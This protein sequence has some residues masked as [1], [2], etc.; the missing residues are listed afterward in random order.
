MNVKLTN[1]KQVVE[2][3]ARALFLLSNLRFYEK[4][5]ESTLAIAV[6]CK[7]ETVEQWEKRIDE[8]LQVLG[9]EGFKTLKEL[10]E[11]LTPKKEVNENKLD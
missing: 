6:L 9:M 8:W 1:E 3:A 10:I 4:E 2:I 5:H 7:D 11:E